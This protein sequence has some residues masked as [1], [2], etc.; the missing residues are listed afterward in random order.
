MMNDTPRRGRG[1]LAPTTNGQ[2][3]GDPPAINRIPAELKERPQWVLWK[4][5]VRGGKAT[6]V[7]YQARRPRSKART[8]D[9][10]TWATFDAA[11]AA[12]LRGGF[13]GIGFV[14]SADDPYFGCDLDDCLINV[15]E[16][17]S[18]A[19][20]I[21]PKLE[22]TFGDISPSGR[23]IKFIGKGQLPDGMGTRRAGMAPDGTGAIEVYDR[24]RFFTITGN[25][26]GD[27]LE[28]AELPDV[29][30]DLYRLAKERP[31]EGGRKRRSKP[32]PAAD[33]DST[34]FD[35][36]GVVHDDEEVLGVAGENMRFNALWHGQ[37]TGHYPSQNEADLGLCNHLASYCG[38]DQLD[39]V[40]RL[41]LR[42]EL[43]KREK[44]SVRKDY[45]ARTVAKAYA[46][47]T[48]YY[49]WPSRDRPSA[50]PGGNGNGRGDPDA[51]LAKVLRTDTGN[52]QRLATRFGG[53]IRYCH[54]W[55]KWLHYDGR[56][57]KIDDD[58]SV[59]RLAK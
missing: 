34:L 52:G 31:T 17:A 24:K 16:I 1:Q 48:E 33:G 43:G 12:Y 14:F 37:W 50:D 5:E 11:W 51:Q 20:P 40:G 18:W 35:R 47:R 41:F 49:Q 57:W 26:W 22:P 19:V 39:Q 55:S 28:I 45:L 58:A 21:L 32:R 15:D 25:V 56:R 54:P 59:R 46:G 29:A 6:K 2:A 13:D 27:T 44:A 9:P 8:D 3:R 23:G 42:S 4:R 30:L 53:V 36:P 38:P 7:P 10:S